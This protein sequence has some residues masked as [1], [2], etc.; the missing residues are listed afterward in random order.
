[1]T[2]KNPNTIPVEVTKKSLLKQLGGQKNSRI[3]ARLKAN[4]E[5]AIRDIHRYADTQAVYKILPIQ[6][7]NGTVILKNGISFRSD[8]LAKVLKSCKQV[9]IFLVTLGQE[10]DR[11]IKQN[12]I[13]R[14]H[15]AYVLD[16]AASL[17]TEASVEYIQGTI[18][19]NL[20]D[21]QCTTLRYSPGY[22][23]WP[24]EEQ[25]KLFDLLPADSVNVALSENCFMT[26]RKSISGIIGIGPKRRIQK[27]KN[28]C[29]TCSKRECAYRREI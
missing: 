24:I 2:E 23:D 3:S 1:M 16:M 14:P 28:I 18:K 17:A 19:Q 25:K 6:T 11:L 21:D 22:C 12:I 27:I 4:A 15:Y 8:K 26:P 13:R 9:V 10:V 20:N 5:N 7:L 29:W